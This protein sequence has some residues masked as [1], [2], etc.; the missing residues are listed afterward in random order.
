MPRA[1]YLV[2]VGDKFLLST[3]FFTPPAY[4]GRRR[5]LVNKYAP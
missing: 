4:R 1:D 3:R 2:A 5:K